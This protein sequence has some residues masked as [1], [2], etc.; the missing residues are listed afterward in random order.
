MEESLNLKEIEKRVWTSYF[1]DGLYDI[2][3]GCFLLGIGFN[4]AFGNFIGYLITSIGGLIFLFIGK[5][6]IVL[7]RL[8]RVRF[9]SKRKLNIK[10]LSI[11]SVVNTGLLVTL[12]SLRFIPGLPPVRVEGIFIP[13]FFSLLIFIPI[14]LVA[15]FLE[16]NRG[17]IIAV[18]GGF[19]I[20]LTEYLRGYEIET[21]L[22][23]FITFGSTAI[24]IITWGI[25]LFLRFLR[26]YPLQ[27]GEVE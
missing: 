18:M 17:Y 6:Y 21:S 7:P 12:V 20:F 2:L 13:I 11:A 16:F 4:Y 1:Q 24:I 15:F 23:G 22:T 14:S 8:G 10:R 9:G 26:K 27:E 3:L 5:K 19:S 25:I